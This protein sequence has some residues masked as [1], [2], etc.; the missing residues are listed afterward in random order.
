MTVTLG[1]N[2]QVNET[3]G[4]TTDL[5]ITFQAANFIKQ[6]L[7]FL[8]YGGSPIVKT[9]NQTSFH[10][11]QMVRVKVEISVSVGECFLVSRIPD[12]G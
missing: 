12:D 10:M 1:I 7:L 3:L 5:E 9:L 4:I 8:A 2:D 11:R 6:I